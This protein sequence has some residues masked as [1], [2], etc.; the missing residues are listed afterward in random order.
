MWDLESRADLPAQHLS[1]GERRRLEIAR[2]L[3]SRPRLLLL[4]EPVAGMRR[5]EMLGVAAADPLSGRR[6]G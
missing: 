4:D 1:Y 6:K 3:A 5:Q 2:A